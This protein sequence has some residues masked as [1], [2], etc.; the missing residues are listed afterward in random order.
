MYFSTVFLPVSLQYDRAGCLQV[1]ALLS[2]IIGRLEFAAQMVDIGR[3]IFATLQ[4]VSD[5]KGN[6]LCSRQ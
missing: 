5:D 3:Y 1:S 4:L 2:E 6:V